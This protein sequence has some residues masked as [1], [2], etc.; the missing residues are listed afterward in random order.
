M[1]LKQSGFSRRSRGDALSGMNMDHV[2]SLAE[3]G[4]F[5][6]VTAEIQTDLND[7][8]KAIKAYAKASCRS[9]EDLFVF[10]KEMILG[11]AWMMINTLPSVTPPWLV[12]PPL[13][14]LTLRLMLPS[15]V[16]TFQKGLQTPQTG[17]PG[18]PS[19]TSVF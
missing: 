11:A 8:E 14:R 16:T 5:F 12:R 4:G 9:P 17:S 2:S 10:A 1:V 6:K 15:Q 13:L 18:C 7:Y 19:L 3:E